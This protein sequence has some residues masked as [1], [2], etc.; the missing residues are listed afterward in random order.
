MPLLGGGGGE[1]CGGDFGILVGGHACC[2]HD[3]AV[4]Y[5]RQAPGTMPAQLC[6][7]GGEFSGATEPE[8]ALAGRLMWLAVTAV[9]MAMS[10]LASCALSM[11]ESTAA[12]VDNDTGDRHDA[13]RA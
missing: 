4:D 11:P 2:A 9:P 12:A 13:R 6:M 5:S 8:K 7:R 1:A 3:F 10:T